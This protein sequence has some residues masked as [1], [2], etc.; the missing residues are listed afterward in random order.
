MTMAQSAIRYV[1]RR[2]TSLPSP[3]LCAWLCV[4][5]TATGNEDAHARTKM[6]ASEGAGLGESKAAAVTPSAQVRAPHDGGASEAAAKAVATKG[7]LWAGSWSA[8]SGTRGGAPIR[9]APAAGG[10]LFDK[11]RAKVPGCACDC[12]K[13]SVRH[14]RPRHRQI[15]HCRRHALP[16]SS[17]AEYYYSSFAT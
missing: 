10:G 14:G 16:R 1:R 4:C 2:S 7:D 11:R 6:G 5:I 13:L 9:T 12:S 3:L 17:R 15:T 8:D